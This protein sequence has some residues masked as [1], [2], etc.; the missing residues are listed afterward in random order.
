MTIK[1]VKTSGGG[2]GGAGTA[3]VLCMLWC[4]SVEGFICACV[5]VRAWYKNAAG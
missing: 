3:T 4:S 1:K 2:G 5:H